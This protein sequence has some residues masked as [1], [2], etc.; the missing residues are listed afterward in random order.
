MLL[1]YVKSI[2]K[3]NSNYIESVAK[4]WAAEEIF[5]HEQAEEKLRQLLGNGP[6]VAECGKCPGDFPSFAQ[7]QRRTVCAP[8]DGPNGGFRQ[9]MIR[10]AYD[11]CVNSTGRMNF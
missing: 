2:G 10:E 5:T 7:R 3:D 1:A 4:N 9:D 6:D 8:L 11:R